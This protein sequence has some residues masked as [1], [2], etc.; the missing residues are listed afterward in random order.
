MPT[1]NPGVLLC[2]AAFVMVGITGNMIGPTYANLTGRYGIPLADGA[3]F[4]SIQAIGGTVAVL[5]AGRLLDRI[6]ARYVLFTGAALMAAALFLLINTPILGVAYFAMIIYGVGMG[7]LLVGCNVAV[8]RLRPDRA[9]VNINLLNFTYGIGAILGPQLVNVALSQHN[10]LLAYMTGFIFALLVALFFVGLS[11]PVPKQV[12]ITHTTSAH[13][14]SLAALMPFVIL[15]FVYVGM[16]VSFGAWIFTQLRLAASAPEAIAALATS[17]FWGGFTAGRGIISL[18]GTRV[19]APTWLRIGII[20]IGLGSAGL[21]LFGA[22]APASVIC[23]TLVGLGCG[24]VFPSA[25]G[26]L[27]TAFPAN[28]GTASGIVM[29]MGNVSVIIMPRLQGQLGN[30]QNGGIIVTFV[31][32]IILLLVS[33]LVTP[34]P[35]PTGMM[36]PVSGQD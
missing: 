20:T 27:R 35:T 2:N 33:P 18:L 21:L 13:G 12:P 36:S 8:T 15:L 30:G 29:A 10:Y 34:R 31:A 7:S 9:A 5:L 4:T 19:S 28:F 25:L 26:L 16:E 32:A 3:N 24:P 17:L 6:N 1:L 22:S 23:A 14:L 11:I